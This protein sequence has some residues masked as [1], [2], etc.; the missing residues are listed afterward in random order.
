MLRGFQR[1]LWG[2]A[3]L[4]IGVFVCTTSERWVSQAYFGWEFTRTLERPTPALPP[5]PR[6]VD[7]GPALGR[8]EIPS[9]DLS[10]L[11]LEG[12]DGRTL[13]RAVGHIPGTPLPGTLGNAALSAHRDTFFRRLGKVSHGD[14]IWITTLRGHYKYVVESLQVVDPNDNAVLRNA[15][16]PILTLVTCYPFY[17]VGSAP[18]R[19]VVRAVLADAD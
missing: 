12:A 8:L 3:V 2:V 11:Y 13:R 6:I 18:K 1:V 4:A 14:V 9:I 19:F 17:Y 7:G 5:N 10:A 16:R 15:G